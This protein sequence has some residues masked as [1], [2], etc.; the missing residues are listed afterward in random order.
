[1]LRHYVTVQQAEI[2]ELYGL[3]KNEK[4]NGGLSVQIF[5]GL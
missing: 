1:M 2:D 5:Q 4:E 3:G